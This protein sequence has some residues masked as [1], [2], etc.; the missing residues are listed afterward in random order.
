MRSNV[1]SYDFKS[2]LIFEFE[3]ALLCLTVTYIAYKITKL[4]LFRYLF[5]ASA[6]FLPVALIRKYLNYTS[7][8]QH[9]VKATLRLN[10]KIPYLKLLLVAV[11]T[12]AMRYIPPL[13][14]ALA[15]ALGTL[16]GLVNEVRLLQ[17]GVRPLPIA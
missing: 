14:F 4:N 12:L 16:Q 9:V 17:S 7:C 5:V 1:P 6:A 11:G 8:M 15:I 3:V 13:G 10:A 2:G